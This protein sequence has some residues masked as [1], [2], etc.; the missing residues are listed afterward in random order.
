VTR[1][2]IPQPI[3]DLAHARSAARAA[4]DWA[5]ADR[6]RGEIEVAGW[7]V[8]DSGTDFRLEPAAAPVV[9]LDGLVRYGRS[10]AVPSRLDEPATGPAT[11]ILAATGR[12]AELERAFTALAATSPAGIQIVVV[13]DA[14]SAER[15]RQLVADRGTAGGVHDVEI[16][17]T[18]GPLNPGVAQ[19]MGLRR[20]GGAIVALMDVSLEPTGDIVTPLI[21]ALDDPTVAAVGASG[22][23]SAD[24][25]RF[26]D[27]AAG[28]A[29]AIT[30]DLLA[31]R[32]ADAVE[33]GPLDEGFRSLRHLVLWWSLVLRDGG[34]GE[35]HRRAV[36]L[37]NLAVH[38]HEPVGE[39]PRP[40][41]EEQRLAKRSLYR[42]N[43][44]FRSRRDLGVQPSSS[45][46]T[47]AVLH[48]GNT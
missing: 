15:I 18:S 8:I 36:V 25:R 10:D 11:V 34:Q 41:A 26:E 39:P 12:P 24:L 45:A 28:D 33:R 21:D 27:V 19:N 47:E 3:L 37:P 17:E 16:L 46:A 2:Y 9:E 31:V 23:Y 22:V 44:W 42:L 1:T 14:P 38:R 48:R 7:K 6:L 40:G 13:T 32:R 29:A 30:D 35:R 43:D 20:A 5:E 4:R